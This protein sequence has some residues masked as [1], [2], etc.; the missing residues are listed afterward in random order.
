VAVGACVSVCGAVGFVGLIAPVLAR[1]LTGGHPGGALWP[2]ALIGAMLLLGAD[3]LTRLAPLGRTIPLGVVTATLGTPLF[4]WLL[5]RMR[6][7][8]MP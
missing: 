1:R 3:L 8:L 5:L 4:L 6:W 7:R 2:A